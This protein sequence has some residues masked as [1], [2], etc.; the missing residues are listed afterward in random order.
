MA[1]E[2]FEILGIKPL[3]MSDCEYENLYRVGIEYGNDICPYA[4]D[5][6]STSRCSQ[7]AYST[8]NTEVFP[9]LTSSFYIKAWTLVTKFLKVVPIAE[10][11]DEFKY[12]AIMHLAELKEVS[13]K[14][15]EDLRNYIYDNST[16]QGRTWRYYVERV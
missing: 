4:E 1:N 14:S 11:E 16:L 9:E 15:I 3:M 6:N 10:T 5:E 13:S 2:I 12:R 7:C 8:L